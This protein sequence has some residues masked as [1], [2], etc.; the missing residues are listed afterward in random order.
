MFALLDLFVLSLSIH[1]HPQEPPPSYLFEDLGSLG[2][3][4]LSFGNG[5]NDDGLVVGTN[6]DA[7]WNR[8]AVMFDL[9][10]VLPP[11]FL[12]DL[13]SGYSLAMGVSNSGKII[14][15][16]PNSSRT[17]VLTILWESAAAFPVPLNVSPEVNLHREN[18]AW[19][20][21]DHHKNVAGAGLTDRSP[22]RY[23]PLVYQA[24]LDRVLVYDRNLADWYEGEAWDVNDHGVAVGRMRPTMSGSVW[25]P[26]RAVLLYDSMIYE[27]DVPPGCES[28]ARAIN[29]KGLVVGWAQASA[30]TKRLQAFSWD[31]TTQVFTDL[32]TLH[33]TDLWS[34]AL[35]VN[36][37]GV[38]VGA[39]RSPAPPSAAIDPGQVGIVVVDGVMHD[40]N[41][42]IY[43]YDAGGNLVPETSYEI[44]KAAAVNC[45]GQIAG[46]A[47]LASNGSRTRA[48]RLTPL[49]LVSQ[50]QRDRVIAAAVRRFAQAGAAP[51]PPAPPPAGAP[52][53]TSNRHDGPMDWGV[54][55]VAA[56]G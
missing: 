53:P 16:G 52:L 13:G 31:R 40:L 19:A 49:A 7:S 55:A 44:V 2:P 30:S 45:S 48:F 56:G 51:D 47:R 11:V 20:I 9:H 41:E 46:T 12:G 32:G 21:S 43:T 17:M 35:D 26:L 10:A 23:Q 18:I 25:P 6:M 15:F 54:V 22:D 4:D 50:S 5:I 3:Q 39:N 38:I 8:V 28:M 29:N 14:G 37:D 36:D 33:A 42:L 34:E 1:P 24:S 27:I